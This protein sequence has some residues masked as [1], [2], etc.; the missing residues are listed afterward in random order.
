MEL[1]KEDL[2]KLEEMSGALMSPEEIAILLDIVPDE[3]K[4]FR[5]MCLEHDRSEIY[6]AYQKGR[7]N[8]KLKLRETIVKLAMAGSPAAEPIAIKFINEQET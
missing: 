1:N 8:T 5:S 4:L 3:R 7:L 2:Q 6:T